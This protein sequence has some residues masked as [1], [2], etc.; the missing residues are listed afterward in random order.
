MNRFQQVARFSTK[1][2]LLAQV[3]S[4][5]WQKIRLLGNKASRHKRYAFTCSLME[6]AEFGEE[7]SSISDPL[8]P[9]DET[10]IWSAGN[11]LDPSLTVKILD[12]HELLSFRK[13]N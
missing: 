12:R 6:Q 2:S 9:D 3:R 7:R 8:D 11:F 1:T 4:K 10:L 13:G 5:N